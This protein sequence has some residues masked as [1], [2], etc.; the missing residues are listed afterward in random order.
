MKDKFKN[1]SDKTKVQ[2]KIKRQ[3]QM[4]LKLEICRLSKLN[5]RYLNIISQI[6]EKKEKVVETQG[7]S[8]EAAKTNTTELLRCQNRISYL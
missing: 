1:D 5:G 7:N 3:D 6:S 8:E 4:N 2:K